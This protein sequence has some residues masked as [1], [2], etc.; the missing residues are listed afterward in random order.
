M[1]WGG[2]G[3]PGGARE[4]GGA[5][6]AEE[7]D[8]RWV[9]RRLERCLAELRVT[10]GTLCVRVVDAAAM[11]DLHLRF[12]GVPGPTDVLTFDNTEPL[13]ADGA[14]EDTVEPGTGLEIDGDVV[15]CRDVAADA[16]SA[17]GHPLRAELLLY[18]LHGVLHLLGE[19]DTTPDAFARMHAREDA[20]LEA[21]GVG[22]LFSRTPE[23]EPT[24]RGAA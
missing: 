2:L 8:R 10:R 3:E 20:V 11:A 19:D 12:S 21:I 18:M 22:A 6:E 17:A 14:S 23:P 4:A 1:G 15:I 5:D 16:A 7:P 13:A 24:H 9:I